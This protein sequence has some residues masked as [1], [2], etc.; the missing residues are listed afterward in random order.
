MILCS[1]APTAPPMSVTTP[2]SSSSTITVQWGSVP[3]IHQNGVITGYSVQYEVMGSGNTMTMPVGG[4]DT[5]QTTIGDLMSSTTYSI[6][7]AAVNSEGTGVYSDPPA[8]QL[9]QGLDLVE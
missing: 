6:Q 5:T 7:V 1:V 9:T 8:N 3:C 4:A 2:S